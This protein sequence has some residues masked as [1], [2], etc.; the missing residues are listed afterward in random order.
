MTKHAFLI[1]VAG[2]GFSSCSVSSY[3]QIHHLE[4][5][6]SLN[7]KDDR[8]E[9]ED[10]YC[11][12]TYNFWGRDGSNT[13]WV[14]NKSEEVICFLNDESFVI[15]N[16]VA[17]PFYK[18][19]VYGSSVRTGIASV[20][21]RYGSMTE[22]YKPAS[23]SLVQTTTSAATQ[24]S[25][26][27]VASESSVTRHEE[28]VI[29]I[30]PHSYRNLTSFVFSESTFKACDLYRYPNGKKSSSK[31]F[32]KNNT[33]LTIRNHI[34]YT[35][36]KDGDKRRF[37]NIFWLRRVINMTESNFFESKN[38]EICGKKT[39]N[40]VNYYRHYTP[41]GYYLRYLGTS[42]NTAKK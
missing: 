19:E 21:G 17:S 42:S 9:Y 13:I 24:S 36:G 4:A 27:A 1:I 26:A 14:Y 37:E 10:E 35:V 34:V 16:E 38:E 3:Y 31:V 33:P 29:C 15:R 39:Y 18:N 20:T 32:T 2:I 30:P 6:G 5:E 7:S 12:I 40:R 11:R 8:F 25:G 22:S 41:K 28:K 23:L